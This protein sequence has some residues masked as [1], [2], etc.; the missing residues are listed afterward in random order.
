[1][2][3]DVIGDA[4]SVSKMVVSQSDALNTFCYT[5]FGPHSYIVWRLF[6]NGHDAGVCL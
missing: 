5:V 4:I 3:Y 6:T 1:M 2:V